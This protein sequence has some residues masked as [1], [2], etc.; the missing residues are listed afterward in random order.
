MDSKGVSSELV[1][2]VSASLRKIGCRY[3]QVRKTCKSRIMSV[4]V[5][6]VNRFESLAVD[7]CSDNNVE[8]AHIVDLKSKVL[9][10]KMRKQL[11]LAT[12]NVSG[13]IVSARDC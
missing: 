7:T 11:R 12:W 10:S 1:K 13:C 6:C 9:A 8:D 2:Q 5:H 4:P 3:E